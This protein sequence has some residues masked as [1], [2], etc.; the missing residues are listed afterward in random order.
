MG[1]DRG[2]HAPSQQTLQDD[3][4]YMVVVDEGTSIAKAKGWPRGA[5]QLSQDFSQFVSDAAQ[6]ASGSVDTPESVES[7]ISTLAANC[8]IAQG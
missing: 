7:D 2:T 3:L 4:Q 5:S 6:Y 1:R 8:S